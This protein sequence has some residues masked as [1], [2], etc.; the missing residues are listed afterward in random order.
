M[1]NLLLLS[2]FCWFTMTNSQAQDVLAFPESNLKPL[3][4]V[5]LNVCMQQTSAMME[6]LAGKGVEHVAELQKRAEQLTYQGNHAI[7]AEVFE[8]LL[9]INQ[10]EYGKEDIRYVHALVDLARVYVLLIR[11]TEAVGMYEEALTTLENIKGKSSMDYLTILNEKLLTYTRVQ[12][13]EQAA[14][15]AEEGLE[16]LQKMGERN[17]LYSG[18][19]LNNLGVCY[20]SMKVYSKGVE[21]YQKAFEKVQKHPRYA[22]SVAANLAEALV[23][24][25]KKKEGEALLNKY[26]AIA[27]GEITG[28]DLTYARVWMQYGVAYMTIG[29][30][31]KAEEVLE[32]AFVTN[33][34]SLTTVEDIPNEADDLMF[35]NHFLA[36]CGQAGLM[37]YSVELYK[38]MYE[39]TGDVAHLQRGYKVVQAM[40]KYGENLMNS[41]LSEENKLIL[42]RLGAAVL[43]DR[44]LFYAYELHQ[45]TGDDRYLRDAFFWSERSKSTLLTNALRSKQNQ[46][47]LNLPEELKAQQKAYKKTLG[48]LNKQKIEATT[49]EEKARVTQ[50]LNELKIKIDG[51][52]KE[53]QEQYPSYYKHRYDEQLSDLAVVQDH[54]NSDQVLLEY[55]LGIEDEHNYA[56][57]VSKRTVKFLQLDVAKEELEEQ[58]KQLRKSLSDYEFLSNQPNESKEQYKQSATYFYNKIIEPLLTDAMKGKHLI[59]VPDGSL[60]HL[61]FEVFLTAEA[62]Q[63]DDY[64]KLPYLL[65]DYSISYS[66]SA[67]IYQAQTA[68]YVQEPIEQKGVLAFAAEYSSPVTSTTLR[69]RRGE[70]IAN[71]RKGLQPLPGAEK[72][73]E[74]M[75]EHLYG[76]FFKGLDANEQNFKSTAKDYEIIHLAMHGVLDP[77]SPILSSLVFSEDSSTQ[78]DNFLRAFEIAQLDLKAD[79]VVLSACET[80]YG[81]FLQGEGIMSLAHSFAYAGASSVLMSLWQVNDYSTGV[82]M[83]NYYI[84]IGK[85]LTK[86]R[87][88]Q[89]AKL[90][91]LDETDSPIALHPAFWAAFVQQGDISPLDLVCKTGLRFSQMRTIGGILLLIL[92]I[93]GFA[94]WMTQKR[95]K[96]KGA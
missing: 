54:L 20:K 29:D 28:K 31:E 58:T 18:I 66:Y 55:F 71:I 19:F 50:E 83:K 68:S 17:P 48:T 33:S 35:D 63:A 86:D 60:G 24:V 78:E 3:G 52:K 23:Y 72:E 36:T 15:L 27:K 43:F 6:E 51:F 89:E 14:N 9:T 13:F 80:G 37:M 2:L 21:Y 5:P 12:D 85:G 39:A 22:I 62:Q 44:C 4:N 57:V 82:I 56:F 42:F 96:V 73:V 1:K 65:K 90:Q 53:I 26:Y 45:A 46:S 59:V 49:E 67:T 70:D 84:N 25:G 91:Y 61:P 64:A 10:E 87:A 40:S 16:T 88:L 34:L 75:S 41:Y 94:W 30:F 32:R 93:G 92:F 69:S 77:R 95:K 74:L 11:Y 8:Q 81:K 38:Q 79:L 47:Y 7:A 76:E